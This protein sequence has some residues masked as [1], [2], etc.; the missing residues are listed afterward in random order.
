ML[1][2]FLF[3]GYQHSTYIS[4][5]EWAVLPSCQCWQDSPILHNT[6]IPKHNIKFY[7]LLKPKES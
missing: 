1:M 5:S 4:C 2:L 6:K 7:L 3:I